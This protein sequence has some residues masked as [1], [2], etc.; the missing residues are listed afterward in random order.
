MKDI[1]KAKIQLVK[2]VHTF[3]KPLGFK[4]KGPTWIREKDEVFQIV[5][6]QSEF[7]YKIF[8]NL[9]IFV[10]ILEPDIIPSVEYQCHIRSRIEALADYYLNNPEELIK[11]IIEPD[12]I[13]GVTK[14]FNFYSGEVNM[15]TDVDEIKRGE[16]IIRLI[17]KI[18]LPF[19]DDFDTVDKIKKIKEYPFSESVPLH[20]WLLEKVFNMSF[21]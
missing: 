9:G 14:Y 6:L 3:L 1:Q 4:K 16:I 15:K 8:I 12:F 17:E 7:G 11:G 21:S 13:M 5:N 19:F 2:S 10:K 18:A 20:R